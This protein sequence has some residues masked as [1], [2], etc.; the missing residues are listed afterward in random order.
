[1]EVRARLSA[2]IVRVVTTIAI[3]KVALGLGAACVMMALSSASLTSRYALMLVHVLVFAGVGLFLRLGS[4]R[5]LRAELLGGL[6][7][8][9]A[10]LFADRLITPFDV[11]DSLAHLP[12]QTLFSLQVDA[13]TPYFIWLFVYEFPSAPAIRPGG[14]L[15]GVITLSLFLGLLLFL[16]NLAALIL[17]LISNTHFVTEFLFHFS[18]HNTRSIYWPSQYI[19]SVAAFAFLVRKTQRAPLEERRRASLL[20][21]G[22]V[23]G[24]SPMVIWAT[25]WSL[26]PQMED[27]LPLRRRRLGDLSGVPIKSG[28]HCLCCRGTQ[29]ARCPLGGT[30]GPPVC[31]GSLLGHSHGSSSNGSPRCECLPR[32]ARDNRC[33]ALHVE[34]RF[35]ICPRRCRHDHIA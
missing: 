8:L 5:D 6:L 11:V 24:T 16:A 15:R 34:E 26:I 22:L 27:V 32:Q 4:H 21:W 29:G 35:A 33:C 30:T 25:L 2:Q 13:F 28:P 20:L 19:L 9:V 23:L 12:L 3:L 17:S 14:W 18:R 1:M 7:L 31:T 10:A